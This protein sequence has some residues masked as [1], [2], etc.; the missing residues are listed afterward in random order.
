MTRARWYIYADEHIEKS[1]IDSLRKAGFNILSVIET[2]EYQGKDDNFHYN[3]ARQ[4]NRFLLT[5]D[6]GFWDN[7][8][9]PLRTSPAIIIVT[10]K[11]SKI[12]V[13]M[14]IAFR[15]ML[16]AFLTPQRGVRNSQIKFKLSETNINYQYID[17]YTGLEVS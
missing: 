3:K 7:K 5:R 1:T 6:Q 15:A 8:K 17:L 14:L 9:Y 2:S 10:T 11:D 16:Y 13:E 4:L 12:D